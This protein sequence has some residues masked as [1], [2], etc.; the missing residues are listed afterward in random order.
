[1][2]L[3]AFPIAYPSTRTKALVVFLFFYRTKLRGV[4]IFSRKRFEGRNT[5]RPVRL[6]PILI[7]KAN[8]AKAECLHGEAA[9]SEGTR[10]RSCLFGAR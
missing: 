2:K 7:A 4:R 5:L 1:M 9:A 3:F 6:L 10:S 8:E